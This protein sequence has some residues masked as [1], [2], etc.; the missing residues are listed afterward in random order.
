MVTELWAPKGSTTEPWESVN[1][2][3]FIEKAKNFLRAFDAEELAQKKE[4]EAA[5]KGS[6]DEL[7]RTLAEES[8]TLEVYCSRA[9]NL[10]GV[11][12]GNEY[13]TSCKFIKD[14]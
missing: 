1:V 5:K 9:Q 3:I 7:T 2:N 13:V 14:G 10:E 6:L 4:I 8:R 12:C 11:P